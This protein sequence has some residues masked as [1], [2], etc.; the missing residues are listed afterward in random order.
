MVDP[1]WQAQRQE[2]MRNIRQDMQR[3]WAPPRQ[4]EMP[5]RAGEG[6]TAQPQDYEMQGA[7]P[8]ADQRG[9]RRLSP[10]ARQQ[11]R[12]DLRE[13]AREMYIQR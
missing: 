8:P 13:A 6:R 10:E 9:L 11:L 7:E 1:D 4:M 3:Q 5:R 12:R 2:R